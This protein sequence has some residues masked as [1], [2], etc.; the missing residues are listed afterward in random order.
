MI[1]QST[2]STADLESATTSRMVTMAQ[3]LIARGA[4]V[5]G[6]T[7]PSTITPGRIIRTDVTYRSP[8]GRVVGISLITDSLGHYADL[9]TLGG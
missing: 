3:R 6:H 9:Y 1:V 7:Y 2:R 8:M 4:T 5:E